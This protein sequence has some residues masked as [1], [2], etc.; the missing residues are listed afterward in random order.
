VEACGGNG[1]DSNGF[2]TIDDSG[3]VE[4]GVKFTADAPVKITGVRVYRVDTGSLTGSLWKADGT[5]LATGQFTAYSGANGWQDLTFATPIQIQGGVTYIASYFAPTADYAFEWR[6]FA[7]RSL[8]VGPITAM[9]SVEGDRNGVYCYV[10]EDCGLFPTNSYW[11][12]NYWVTPLWVADTTPPIVDL[13]CPSDVL[14]GDTA[15][16]T[17]SASDE[18]GGT[19]LVGPAMGQVLVDTGSVGLKTASVPAGTATDNAGNASL[20]TSCQYSVIY[21]FTG[22]FSPV[23]MNGVYNKA[24]AGSAIPV[25]FSLSGYQGMSILAGNPT[26]AVGTCTAGTTDSIEET[27]T[28]GSSSLSY[29]AARDQYVYVWKTQKTWAGK[30][31]T[32]TVTI[33][34][35]TSH[36]AL[37]S[38]TK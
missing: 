9:E 8:T 1:P 35:G 24:K 3:G 37:F 16:A 12:T 22:F 36:T 34:D 29:D 38:L 11:D 13:T 21:P 7:G 25:K 4:L 26:F 23:D 30:C 18:S 10:G 2:C 6:F 28:A 20:A 33:N 14:L 5:L 19:G 32:L 17:W 31:G 27:V 15:F